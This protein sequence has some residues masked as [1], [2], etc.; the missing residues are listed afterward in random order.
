M[1][2][3][4]LQKLKTSKS[5]PWF[6]QTSDMLNRVV[7]AMLAMLGEA[8]IHYETTWHTDVFTLTVTGLNLTAVS[9][10]LWNTIMGFSFQ[11]FFYRA[12]KSHS[13]GIK[14]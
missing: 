14:K 10:L 2:N 8:G 7:S 1:Q 12:T 4:V 11:E 3:F 6:S 13:R 9:H 5:V